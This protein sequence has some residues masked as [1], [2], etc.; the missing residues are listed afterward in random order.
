[1]AERRGMCALEAEVLGHLWA[2]GAP[3]SPGEVLEAMGGELAYSSVMTILVRLWKKG[4][5]DRERR[6]RAYVYRPVMSEAELIASRMR[7]TLDRTGD[8]EA[9]LSQ[10]VGTLTGRDERALRRILGDAA[11]RDELGAPPAGSCGHRLGSG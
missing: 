8:R 11:R 10:F 9:A 5:A 1:M 3:A 4:L 7:A 6:G 2:I